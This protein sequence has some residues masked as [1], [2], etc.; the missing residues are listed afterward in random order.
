M[1]PDE[2]DEGG[3]GCLPSGCFWRIP[4]PM[5]RPALGTVSVRAV[6]GSRR[7]FLLPKLV[8][9]ELTWWTIPRQ[10][11]AVPGPGTSPAWWRVGAYWDLAMMPALASARRPNGG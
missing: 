3:H 11:G 5:A 4:P 6:V 1:I 2:R 9:R 10:G 8:F 7:N